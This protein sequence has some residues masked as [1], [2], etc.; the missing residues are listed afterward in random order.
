[1]RAIDAVG[2]H[3]A[4]TSISTLQIEAMGHDYFIGQSERPEGPFIVRYLSTSEKRDVTGGR[5]HIE[6]QQRFMQ[7]PDWAGAG[8]ATIVDGDAAAIA[9]GD[10]FV[11]AGRRAFDDGRERIEL[12]PERLLLVALAALDLAVAPDVR[13]HG[14]TQRVVTFGWRGRR[15]RLM[16]D[17]GDMVP[18]VLELSEDTSGI[19]GMVRQTT[20]YSL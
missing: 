5:S 8:T 11:P 3:A 12:A 4:L 7:V 9:R 18:T 17:V 14:I 20:S 10:R 1:V 19:W 6:T 15:A 2:G 16:I 13:V